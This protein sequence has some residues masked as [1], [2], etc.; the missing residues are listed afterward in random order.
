[1]CALGLLERVRS[2]QRRIDPEVDDVLNA[3]VA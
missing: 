3:L 1:M 2:A